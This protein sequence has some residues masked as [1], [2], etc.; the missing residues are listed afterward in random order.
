MSV[1]AYHRFGDDRYPS[2]NISEEVFEEQLKYL[3]TNNYTV[4]TLR[5][6]SDRMKE[7]TLPEKADGFDCR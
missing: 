7:G 1:F 3:E 5:A 6:A 4:L 2:T